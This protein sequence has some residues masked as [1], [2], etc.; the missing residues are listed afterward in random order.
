M[1]TVSFVWNGPS[2]SSLFVNWISV[3]PLPARSAL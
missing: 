1:C 3:Q 2:T